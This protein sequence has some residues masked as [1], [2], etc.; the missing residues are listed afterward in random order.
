MNKRTE[1]TI[2][3]KELLKGLTVISEIDSNVEPIDF[4][5]KETRELVEALLENRSY[6]ELF[7]RRVTTVK[8]WYSEDRVGA[9]ETVRTL[10]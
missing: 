6:F 5:D 3:F 8:D 2:E 9:C 10:V 4:S 7:R 1:K